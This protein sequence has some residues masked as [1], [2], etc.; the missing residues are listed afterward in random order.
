ML[1]SFVNDQRFLREGLKR[2]VSLRLLFPLISMSVIATSLKGWEGQEVER[3]GGEG[4][5]EEGMRYN[6]GLFLT[7]LDNLI[8]G[9]D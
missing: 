6:L 3:V 5:Y 8:P 7:I 4:M 9:G 2:G 1:V